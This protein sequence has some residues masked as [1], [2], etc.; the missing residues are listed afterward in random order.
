MAM[1]TSNFTDSALDER[2]RKHM[3]DAFEASPL[4]YTQYFNVEQSDNYR[5]IVAAYAGFGA[6]PQKSEGEAYAVDDVA[7]RFTY[8]FTS[9]TYALAF[10]VSKEMRRDEQIRLIDKAAKS[11]GR[12]ANETLGVTA[13]GVLNNG[14]SNSYTKGDGIELFSS[15]HPTAGST[16]QNELTTPADLTN[17][18][19][20]EA[21]YT[22]GSTVDH[23][24]K[25]LNLRVKTMIVPLQNEK[26]AAQI[27]GSTLEAYTTDNQVNYFRSKGIGLVVDGYITDTDSWYLQS[28][29]HG[30]TNFVRQT[31]EETVYDEQGTN[32]RV[33]ALDM[34]ASF[35]VEDWRGTFGVEGGA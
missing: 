18:S 23:R 31:P 28:E 21:L 12:S 27:L 10:K 35:D 14:F 22:F 32:S 33:Y 26:T 4:A 6:M 11:L 2:V 7:K 1:L 5:E 30:L 15:L 34:R 9:L 20:D 13:A 24:G 16:E 3:F 8:T 29:N 19:L 17:A 25:L